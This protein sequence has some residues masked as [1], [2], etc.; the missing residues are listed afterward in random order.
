MSGDAL[1]VGERVSWDEL[2]RVQSISA[3]TNRVDFRADKTIPT[4][5]EWRRVPGFEAEYLVSELGDVWSLKQRRLIRGHTDATGYTAVELRKS[6]K[7]TKRRLYQLVAWAF[8]GPQQSGVICRHINNDR[9]DNRAANLQYGTRKD[10]ARDRMRH[11]TST[12]GEKAWN[13]KLSW[14]SV[15]A[16]RESKESAVALAERYG[17]SRKTILHVRRYASWVPVTY[18]AEAKEGGS[19]CAERRAA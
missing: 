1:A 6:G 12:R 18:L 5:R 3:Y 13:A 17:V 4:D 10:N 14:S 2:M 8:L 9:S 11:G 19:P 16:I 7:A 15:C